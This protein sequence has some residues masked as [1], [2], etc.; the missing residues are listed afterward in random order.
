MVEDKNVDATVCE[1]QD[2]YVGGPGTFVAKNKTSPYFFGPVG[3]HIQ[4]APVTCFQ[5]LQAFTSLC[6]CYLVLAIVS[7]YYYYLIL[8]ESHFPA[9]RLLR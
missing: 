3:N 6:L 2:R 7:C 1:E 8:L 4:D 9:F 5:V